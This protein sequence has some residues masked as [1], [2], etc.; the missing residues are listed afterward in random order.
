MSAGDIVSGIGRGFRE[1]PGLIRK[2][3]KPG[4][5][6]GDRSANQFSEMGDFQTGDEGR[7][8]RLQALSRRF[9]GRTAPTAEA[10]TEARSRQM[11]AIAMLQGMAQGTGPSAASIQAQQSADAGL[12]QQQ[13][14]AAGGGAGAQRAAVQQ[15]SLQQGTVAGQA[16]LARAQEQIA[17]TQQLTGAL[18]GLRGQD[19]ALNFSNLQSLLQTQALNQA[20][21]LGAEQLVGQDL[22]LRQQAMLEQERQRT[23]RFLGMLNVPTGQ[24]QLI[25][26][27]TGLLNIPPASNR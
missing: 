9:G 24:E 20:G 12:R 27:V 23:Q 25:G 3:A 14:M 21:Q 15:G 19:Q 13:A 1:I 26:A 16:A 4:N 11:R 7:T 18:Q 8:D 6:F 2:T 17:A 22:G 10:A 5:L